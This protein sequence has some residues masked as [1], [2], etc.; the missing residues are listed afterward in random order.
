MPLLDK[1]TL[2]TDVGIIIIRQFSDWQSF[3]DICVLAQFWTVY[4]I[5]SEMPDASNLAQYAR[6][7]RL[8]PVDGT[9]QASAPIEMKAEAGRERK[10]GA[11]ALSSL[12]L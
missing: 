3:R 8:T 7:L 5:K 11:R 12:L 1:Y 10:C 2:I 4:Q 6:L 9:P